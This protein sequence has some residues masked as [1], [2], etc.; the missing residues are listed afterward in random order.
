MND[1]SK[2]TELAFIQW[3]YIDPKRSH[4][5]ESTFN[6]TIFILGCP[7]G[8]TKKKRRG[9]WPSAKIFGR[10]SV[11]AFGRPLEWE[12]GKTSSTP[13]SILPSYFLF[14]HVIFTAS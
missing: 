8:Q 9:F 11:A 4:S 10:Y 13:T 12:S 1:T 7:A 2:K 3:R 5:T 14:G 6:P